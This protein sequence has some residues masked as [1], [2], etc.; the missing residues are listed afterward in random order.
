MYNLIVLKNNLAIEWE[1]NFIHDP[2]P[3]FHYTNLSSKVIYYH[4][5]IFLSIQRFCL[6]D[7]NVKKNLQP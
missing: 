6:S 2:N 5:Y 1:L 7:S 3:C 4:L